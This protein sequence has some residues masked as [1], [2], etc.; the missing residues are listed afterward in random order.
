MRYSRRIFLH[1]PLGIHWAGTLHAHI[2]SLYFNI[3]FDTNF[4][5]S[6][7]VALFKEP[8]LQDSKP[9]DFCDHL[10]TDG[11]SDFTGTTPTKI[12]RKLF[13]SLVSLPREVASDYL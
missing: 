4:F 8:D 1:Q 2:L 11:L 12:L 5:F 6:F 3:I 9:T 10:S 13:E 7:Q